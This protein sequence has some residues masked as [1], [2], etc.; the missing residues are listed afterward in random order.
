MN[1]LHF[2]AFG[3]FAVS[4]LISGV[5]IHL[6]ISKGK[7]LFF[8]RSTYIGESLLLG[9]S[10]IIGL[11]MILGFCHLYRPVPL[12]GVALSGYLFLL[13]RNMRETL[14]KILFA[15]MNI[16]LPLAILWAFLAFFIFRNCFYLLDVDSVMGYAFTHRFW[17]EA[18]TNLVGTDADYWPIFLPQYD[19]V[20][21]ALGIGLFG[22]GLL[23]GGLVSLYWRLIVVLLIFGYTS[24]RFSRWHGLAAVFLILLDDHMFYSGVNAWVII[25]SALVAL[26]FAAAYNLWE[27][28]GRDGAFRLVLGIIFLS[29]MVANK[30]QSLWIVFFLL[31]MSALFQSNIAEKAKIILKERRY[32][33]AVLLAVIF[34]STWYVKNTIV[35][36]T[37]IFFKFA[38]TVG[39]LGWT[40]EQEK[41]MLTI[42]SGLSFSKAIKYLSFN[43]VWAGVYALKYLWMAICFLPI[44]LIVVLRRE[45]FNRDALLELFY[46]VG[47]SI[48]TVLG[49]SLT[50]HYEPRY[51]RF[52]IGIFVFA[53]IFSM[54][55]ILV[56]CFNLKNKWIII[57]V[58]GL[59][60]IAGYKVGFEQGGSFKRPTFEENWKVLTSRMSMD[61]VIDKY[62]PAVNPIRRVMEANPDKVSSLAYHIPE[63]H[64]QFPLIFL[65]IKPVVCTWRSSL[66]KWDSYIS[67]ELIVKDLKEH[68]VEWVLTERPAPQDYAI[69]PAAEFA[70]TLIK[71]ERYPK[72][73]LYDYGFPREFIELKY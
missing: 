71:V 67:E 10:W 73:G 44:L 47:I 54:N 69:Q 30:Y 19:S 24:Y 65:P 29:Q 33:L 23:F 28:R 58:I 72:M 61:E 68:G 13:N 39:G 2:F 17:L 3:I 48:L 27:S 38:G 42:L 55:Y 32:W 45:K 56:H 22:D 25:N 21:Y 9:S 7:S 5:R 53:A 26:G 60:S 12:W 46:W 40:P 37:P 18:G 43:F 66:V 31:G 52:F 41:V 49:T 8:N 50:A 4:A 15:K 35:T 36:G 59:L 62:Y 64:M 57:G 16:D 14:T 11:M 34:S 6:F 70:K 63:Q 51:Y 20:P 1:Y